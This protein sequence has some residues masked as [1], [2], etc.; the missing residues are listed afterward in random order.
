VLLGRRALRV[1]RV[2][3][4]AISKGTAVL[5]AQSSPVAFLDAG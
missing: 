4:A 1:N 5:V 3:V 2:I